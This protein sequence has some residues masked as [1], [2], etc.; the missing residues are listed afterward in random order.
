MSTLIDRDNQSK[1]LGKNVSKSQSISIVNDGA[2]K[3]SSVNVKN[4]T[5][6][7]IPGNGNGNDGNVLV[8][9]FVQNLLK[10]GSGNHNV[11]NNVVDVNQTVANASLIWICC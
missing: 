6:G 10:P 2:P 8:D 3:P 1:N 11:V 9:P 5:A 7:R 4:V